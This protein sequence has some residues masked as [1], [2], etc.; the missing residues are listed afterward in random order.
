VN[1]D[2]RFMAV[3]IS[4]SMRTRGSSHPNPNV[5]CILVKDGRIVGRGWTQAGGRPHAEA[6]ALA[7]AGTSAQ[8]ATAYITLEP[9]AHASPR[10]PS[11]AGLLCMAGVVRA[12]VALRD[13]DVRTDGKGLAALAGAGILVETGV[14]AASAAR[15]M[16]G[17]LMRLRHGRPFVTLKLATSLD[18]NIALANGQSRWITG[19]TARAHGHGERSRSHLIIVG[20]RTFESDRPR[21]DVRLPGREACTPA[22]AILGRSGESPDGWQR[23]DRPEAI[24]GHAAHYALIEGGGVT[25]ASFLAAGLVDRLLF[26]RAPI[27]IGGGRPCLADLGLT[28]L[29]QAHGCWQLTD[30]RR[31]GD[32]RLEIYDRMGETECSLVSSQT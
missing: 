24:F 4:L 7:E 25:A 21:L 30:A 22:R 11:C 27:L 2:E 14:M 18:G 32:D 5:G 6:M 23:L 28:R 8:G 10:G 26:Y 15:A 12:V 3:A 31:L 17:W 9:C 1:A 20:R 16:A 29:D 19:E 13:P